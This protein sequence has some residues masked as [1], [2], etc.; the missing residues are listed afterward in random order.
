MYSV[1]RFSFA[2]SLATVDEFAAMLSSDDAFE[3]DGEDSGVAQRVSCSVAKES[4]RA[5]HVA[6][7]EEFILRN[8]RVLKWANEHAVTMT[9]DIAISK[10]ND[11]EGLV[12]CFVFPRS[13]I[14]ILGDYGIELEVSLYP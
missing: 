10:R 7:I 3:F 6:L 1:L 4:H 2:D 13:L 11:L 12:S 9:C 8:S 5:T 14:R